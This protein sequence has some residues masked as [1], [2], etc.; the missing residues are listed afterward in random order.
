MATV[1]KN[2]NASATGY[3]EDN[4]VVVCS[5]SDADALA[6][7]GYGTRFEKTKLS[8]SLYEALF[9]LDQKRL[10]VKRQN[11]E[12]SFQ[13]LLRESR[14]VDKDIWTKYVLYRDL[15]S[16][17]Y[18]VRESS[19]GD[20]GYRVYD[21]GEYPKKAAKYVVFPVREGKPVSASHLDEILHLSESAKKKLIVAVIDRHGDTVYYSLTQYSP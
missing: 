5:Q 10:L 11:N 15:R 12:V 21:R 6:Q 13:D 20:I 4:K 1:E 9:L 8:L 19:L 16:R 14:V 17:G 7:N 18:V 3:L 2:S